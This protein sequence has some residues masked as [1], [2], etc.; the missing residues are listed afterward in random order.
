ME[1]PPLPYYRLDGDGPSETGFSMLVQ[2][3]NGAGGPL[4]GLTGDSVMEA[5]RDFLAAHGATTTSLVLNYPASTT[6]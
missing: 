2:L 1:A 3:Q 5:L 4:A 6:L